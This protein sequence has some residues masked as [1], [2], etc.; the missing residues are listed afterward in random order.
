MYKLTGVTKKYQKGRETV[1]ALAGVDLV[2]EDGEWLAIQGP[3]GHG[4]TTL[5]QVLGGL[6]RPTSGIVEFDGQD[7]AAMRETQVTKVRAVSMGFIFQTFN[8]IPTL[9][10]LENVEV[11]LVPLGAGAEERRARSMAAL[12]NL[13]LGERARHLPSELSGGQ[14]QRVAIA[15]ALVKE[16]KVL[17]ADEPTG[18]LDEGTRDDIMGLLEKLWRDTGLT[19][20]LVTHDSAVARR[21]QRIGIM[22]NGKLSIKQDTRRAAT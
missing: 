7:L 3:T 16:P 6:D 18:N 12:E 10:A 20:I 1:D 5:L 15:R 11:A 17:L 14:Q 21:A 4:K 19:L 2:I 13:G 9:S 8:L 22:Q